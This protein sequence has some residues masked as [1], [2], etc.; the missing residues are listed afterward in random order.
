MTEIKRISL[1]STAS[2]LRSFMAIFSSV[3][4]ILKFIEALLDGFDTHLGERGTALSG[5]QQQRIAIARALYKEPQILILDEA[6]SH[7]DGR[8]EKTVFNT[9]ELL[10]EEGKTIIVIAHRLGTILNA[11]NVVVLED[12]AVVEDGPISEFMEKDGRFK[13]LWNSQ[14]DLSNA[15]SILGKKGS[16]K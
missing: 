5:G 6:T 1:T 3:P 16:V 13:A 2:I 11:D 7:L 14:I 4:G 8:A 15:A 10:R 9:V 12:G